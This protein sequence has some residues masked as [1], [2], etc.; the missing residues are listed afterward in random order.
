[1]EWRNLFYKLNLQFNT[2]CQEIC[3]GFDELIKSRSL[4][5]NQ[6]AIWTLNIKPQK[7]IQIWIPHVLQV[8]VWMN[9]CQR[10]AFLHTLKRVWFSQWFL[11]LLSKG[12]DNVILCHDI[13]LRLIINRYW[14]IS[15][16]DLCN[17]LLMIHSSKQYIN[18][19]SRTALRVTLRV[20]CRFIWVKPASYHTRRNVKVFKIK[21][22]LLSHHQ[23]HVCRGEWKSW[24]HG[25]SSK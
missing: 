2:E 11:R 5:L 7:S 8:S 15:R 19:I 21:S 23:Q 4:H 9:E 17:D 18:N 1:M 16:F 3:Q 10:H 14:S 6:I 20:F 25:N 13:L 12:G 24:I 22:L